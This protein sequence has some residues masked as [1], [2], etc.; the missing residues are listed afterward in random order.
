MKKIFPYIKPQI[1]AIII[2]L[3]IKFIGTIM[4]L[5]LPYILAY[6]IDD[7]VPTG[8]INEV[9]FW[10]I[11]MLIVSAIALIGNI[12]ANRMAAKVARNATRAIRHDLFTKISYLSSSEIDSFTIPS[13]EA[14]LTSDTY[15]L[16]HMIGMMQRMGVRA[17]ILL[18]GGLIIAF[19]LEPALALVLLCLLPFM[20][21]SVW[22]ISKKGVPLYS[23]LQSSVDNMIRAVREHASGIRVI[24]ALSK[25]DYEKERFDEANRDVVKNEKRAGLTMALT[26]PVMNIF[27]NTGLTLVILVGAYRVNAGVSETGKIIAFLSYFTIILNAMMSITR[28]FVMT[29]KGSASA[30]RI[31][32]V[33]SSPGNLPIMADEPI[34]TDAHIVFDDVTFSYNKKKDNIKNISFSLKKGETLGI[35]G[36]TGSGKSTVINLLMRL[37]DTDAG[38]IYINGESVR[39]IPHEKL[40]KMF[41]TVFQGDVLF[42]DTIKNNI[43]FGRNLTD[44]QI[45]NAAKHACAFEFIDS[46]PDKFGHMLTGKGANLSGGQ[47]Q[48][49]LLARAFAGG[50]DILILDDSSSALDYKTDATLRRNIKENYSDTTSIIIAQRISSIK[51]ADLILMLDE[52]EIIGSGTHE[53]L[54]KNCPAYREIADTQMGGGHFE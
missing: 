40:H 24:K 49:V 1:F 31:G 7:V 34:K 18:I 43:D 48:R 25:V 39:S 32:D 47:K 10:G 52:G 8:N 23:S 37:Y 35:I 9:Y 11:A 45:E 38:K 46:L 27:L 53:D 51:H 54:M 36:A 2:G 14:R 13:L 42:A 41:G 29:S 19:S 21:Y 3:T 12:V 6:I 15:H 30:K 22:T 33:L 26:N 5:F 4:D 44:E 17:P 16:H 20:G 50:N 28:I